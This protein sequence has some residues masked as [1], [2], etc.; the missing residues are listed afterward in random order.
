MEQVQPWIWSA[1]QTYL[2]ETEPST[3]II[4]P[5]NPIRTGNVQFIR[6]FSQHQ[7][8][9]SNHSTSIW[10]EVIDRNLKVYIEITNE[11]LKTFE[12]EQGADKRGISSLKWPVFSLGGCRWI[13]AIPPTINLN[14]KS[15]S[16][17]NKVEEERPKIKQLCLRIVNELPKKKFKFKSELPAQ[18]PIINQANQTGSLTHQLKADQRGLMFLA[19]AHLELQMRIRILSHDSNLAEK[20]ASEFAR[21]IVRIPIIR[22]SKRIKRKNLSNDRI[23]QD[24][25]ARADSTESIQ[26]HC[27]YLVNRSFTRSEVNCR[28]EGDERRIYDLSPFAE[29][30]DP[31]EIV[32]MIPSAHNST[33]DKLS[34]LGT[35]S[36]VQRIENS[37]RK[38]GRCTSDQGNLAMPT[39]NPMT[40]NSLTH[41][42]PSDKLTTL[43]AFSSVQLA[44]KSTNGVVRVT[45][46]KGN[47]IIPRNNTIL[48][49]QSTR[50]SP[51]EQ[52]PS[53]RASSS[54]CL[55]EL[56]MNE[57]SRITPDEGNTDLS[58]TITMGVNTRLTTVNPQFDHVDRP[59]KTS[60][61]SNQVEKPRSRP[62]HQ[63]CSPR[64]SLE[65]ESSIGLKNAK[66]TNPTPLA[67]SR[68]R[69]ITTTRP[70]RTTMNSEARSSSRL[71][72]IQARLESKP[73]NSVEPTLPTKS[74]TPIFLGSNQR[75]SEEVTR[76]QKEFVAARRRALMRNRLSRA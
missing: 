56:S 65:R 4:N 25:I 52:L 60:N 37:T 58:N 20:Q 6:F 62:P 35:S 50:D 40:I 76:N 22:R 3:S 23:Q 42:L 30:D 38:L 45:S 51:L 54:V 69:S 44:Q 39:M 11:I 67:Y 19:A 14:S 63:A 46:D 9:H 48:I 29:I 12:F 55:G 57:L 21:G 68:T 75:K 32:K 71:K 31:K 8:G 61:L 74:I 1:C 70:P 17:Q 18:I 59:S 34:S 47:K 64:T 73:I 27:S 43:G 7:F 26:D 41:D 49:N 66:D 5:S 13:W 2:Q 53:L 28:E 15:N 10:A 24:P 16:N 36:N 72:S 33:S